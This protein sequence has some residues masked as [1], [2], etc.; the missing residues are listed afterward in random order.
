[1]LVACLSLLEMR[2]NIC[3]KRSAD[4]SVFFLILNYK[5]KSGD[6]SPA[7]TTKTCA[8]TEAMT[9]NVRI[10]KAAKGSDFQTGGDKVLPG[11]AAAPLLNSLV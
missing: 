2:E 7:G 8:W 6:D 1:M 4:T 11:E 3:P 10:H 9:L 5:K